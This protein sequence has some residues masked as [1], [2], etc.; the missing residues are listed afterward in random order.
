MTTTTPPAWESSNRAESSLQ[1]KMTAALEH[2]AKVE[3]VS[4]DHATG[5]IDVAVGLPHDLAGP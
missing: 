5:V 2:Q 4:I 1:A 3:G